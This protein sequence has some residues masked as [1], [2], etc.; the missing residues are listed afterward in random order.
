MT[1][2]DAD[3]VARAAADAEADQTLDT[4]RS[5]PT[6]Q[7]RGGRLAESGTVRRRGVQIA[8]YRLEEMIGEGG[9][10]TVFRATRDGRAYA[11]KLF[12]W[13]MERT[14]LRWRRFERELRVGMTLRH[15]ALVRVHDWAL[16]RERPFLVMDLL[17]GRTLKR[18]LEQEGPL[19]LVAARGVLAPLV[20]ALDLAHAQ[21]IVHRDVKPEN[22]FLTDGDATPR[23]LDFGLVS[24]LVEEGGTLEG[25]ALGTPRYMP[26][27]Q[28][29]DSRGVGP[30]SDQ[31][32]LAATA[33]EMLTGQ[34]PHVATNLIGLLLAKQEPPWVPQS[35]PPSWR[36]ALR[37]ALDPDPENRFGSV[38]SFLDA[39]TAGQGPF[40]ADAPERA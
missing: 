12:R 23:L 16:Y 24:F 28:L 39:A 26:P 31:Y 14:D 7:P 27:E 37:R 1:A 19:D 22:V 29:I 38:A 35:L 34:P 10:S 17:E 25:Q 18:R 40:P 5:S 36:A 21:G 2:L 33:Y 15:P 32:A 30:W 20:E 3:D 4:P 8:G 11:V 9:S 6:R 13:P